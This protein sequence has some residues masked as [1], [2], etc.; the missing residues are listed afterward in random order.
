M[1]NLQYFQSQ[2]AKAVQSNSSEKA[3]YYR[4]RIT[5]LSKSGKGSQVMLST[6]CLDTAPEMLQ[7][8]IKVWNVRSHDASTRHAFLASKGIPEFIIFQ[9]LTYVGHGK[10]ISD[11]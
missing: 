6:K 3:G 2:L 4:R 5:E 1:T 11:L 9:A 8:A 10:L 7:K